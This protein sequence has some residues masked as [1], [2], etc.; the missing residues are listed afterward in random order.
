[1]D[2]AEESIDAAMTEYL[3]YMQS[4]LNSCFIIYL[5]SLENAISYRLS[6]IS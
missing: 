2:W 1:M 4:S 5:G 3:D 6:A